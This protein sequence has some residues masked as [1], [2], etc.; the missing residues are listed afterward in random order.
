MVWNKRGNKIKGGRGMV[1][2]WGDLYEYDE[3]V[4]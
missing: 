1:G 4:K 2:N 3:V